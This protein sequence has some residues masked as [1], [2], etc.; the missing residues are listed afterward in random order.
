VSGGWGTEIPSAGVFVRGTK[1]F[2]FEVPQVVAAAH[3]VNVV[4]VGLKFPDSIVVQIWVDPSDPIA[5]SFN[6]KLVASTDDG[7]TWG[8]ELYPR[9]YVGDTHLMLP[10][11]LML[12]PSTI[13]YPLT[14]TSAEYPAYLIASDGATVATDPWILT[15]LPEAQGSYGGTPPIAG[16]YPWGKVIRNANDTG[17]LGLWYGTFESDG[18]IYAFTVL[19]CESIDGYH[20]SYKSTL[21]R[22]PGVTTVGANESDLVRLADGSLLSFSRVW[23][24]H[25]FLRARSVDDGSTWTLLPDLPPFSV[26]PCLVHAAGGLLLSA[27]RN[28]DNGGVMRLYWNEAGD[29]ASWSDP[30]NLTAHH[31]YRLPGE[32]IAATMSYTRLVVLDES[33]FIVLYDATP[34]PDAT[35]PPVQNAGTHAYA[36]RFRVE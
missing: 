18:T 33:H 25:T 14:E 4:A 36:C 21:I 28:A 26:N 30:I 29:G 20:W 6:G 24:G 12:F 11:G 22:Y 15:G 9:C 34:D 10:S 32:K 27:G 16:F 7:V 23:A 8:P 2:I 5:P 19:C 13:G 17:W 31:N 1:T 3:G 35:Y